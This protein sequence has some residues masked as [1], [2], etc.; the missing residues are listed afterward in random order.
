M[1]YF[2]GTN[3]SLYLKV[4][5]DFQKFYHIHC[6]IFELNYLLN[7]QMDLSGYL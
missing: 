1:L 3:I 6:N 5:T 7:E 2:M 4:T